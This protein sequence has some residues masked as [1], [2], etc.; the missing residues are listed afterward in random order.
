[1]QAT[2][3]FEKNYF[4]FSAMLAYLPLPI[5][6]ILAT[7]KKSLSSCKKFYSLKTRLTLLSNIF[8]PRCT[9]YTVC[10]AFRR[11]GTHPPLP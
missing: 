4:T 11:S 5:V 8:I 9:Y 1:M 6:K 2:R 7:P 3:E 10:F